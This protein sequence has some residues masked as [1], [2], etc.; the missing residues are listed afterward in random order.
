MD[1]LFFKMEFLSKSDQITELS[2][3]LAGEKID[4]NW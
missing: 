3:L 2:H 1:D 4:T